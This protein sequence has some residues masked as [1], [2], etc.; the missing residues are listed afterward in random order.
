MRALN[1]AKR[2]IKELL[3]DPISLIF[4]IGLPL[5]L[6]II[7]QQFKIPSIEYSL[8]YFTPSIVIFSFG[9]ITLFTAQLVSKDRFTSFLTRLFA[10]P[11][12]SKDYILGYS[13]AIIPIAIIQIILF[14]IVAIILGLEMSVNVILTMLILIPTSLLF[15]ALGI[16][17]GC[18]TNDRQ[19]PVFCSLI[20]QLIAFTSGMWFSIDMVGSV[21]KLICKILPFS[22]TID[23]TRT[24]LLNNGSIIEPLIVVL[25]Y[26][27]FIYI[28]AII[29]FKKRITDDK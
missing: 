27:I 11:M 1:F 15:V 23:L 12:T 5:F 13:L 7:F 22:H 29:T 8:S 25:I 14:F 28:L 18:I 6:L 9:F 20:V 24:F 10:S 16:L 21:Y 17:I 4:C 26:T 19:A 3:R 2:N